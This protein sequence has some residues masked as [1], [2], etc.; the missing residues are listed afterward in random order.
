MIDKQSM[1][2]CERLNLEPWNL[3][4]ARVARELR[5][6]LLPQTDLNALVVADRALSSQALCRLVELPPRIQRQAQRSVDRLNYHLL[7]GSPEKVNA[8]LGR[9]APD[10]SLLPVPW[11]RELLGNLAQPAAEL[12][13]PVQP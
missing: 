8:A 11:L 1:K 9:L 3:A 6:T 4:A 13:E 10:Q 5:I 2:A 7:Q 12:E